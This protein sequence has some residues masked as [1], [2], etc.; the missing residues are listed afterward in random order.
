MKGAEESMVFSVNH[1]VA[2]RAQALAC[3]AC[4]RAGGVL[5]FAALGYPAERARALE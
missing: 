2:P 1:Q 3:G 5:D 4:H